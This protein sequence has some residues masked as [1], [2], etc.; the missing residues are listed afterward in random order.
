MKSKLLLIAAFACLGSIEISADAAKRQSPFGPQHA[1]YS[2]GH[3]DP[4]REYI[5]KHGHRV[6]SKSKK[7]AA[8]RSG[9][10]APADKPAGAL[11]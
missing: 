5:L 11:D 2:S 9:K 8:D 10:P 7:P 4:L 6:D 1:P 3:V